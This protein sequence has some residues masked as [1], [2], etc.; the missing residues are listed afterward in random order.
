MT[1]M[2]MTTIARRIPMNTPAITP[3]VFPERG[4]ITA[5]VDNKIHISNT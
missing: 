4:G 5:A 1:Q 3:F 2:A